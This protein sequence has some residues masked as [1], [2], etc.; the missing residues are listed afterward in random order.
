M[1]KNLCFIKFI[2]AYLLEYRLQLT[3]F[4]LV[5]LIT[6][7]VYF[8]VFYLFYTVIQLDYKIASSIAYVVTVSGHFLLHRV[9]TFSA[10][11]QRVTL[12]SLKYLFMLAINYLIMLSIVYCIVSILGQ[13]P[14]IA[15][16]L[17]NCVTPFISFFA[18]KYFVFIGDYKLVK[19]LGITHTVD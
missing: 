9:F 4:I 14:Y 16:V 8:L 5:G 2:I 6:D 12:N 17:S 10:A 13:S 11:T 15:L 1:V 19:G 18:M 7:G 3:R